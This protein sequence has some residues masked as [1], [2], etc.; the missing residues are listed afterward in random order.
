MGWP[1]FLV[2]WLSWFDFSIGSDCFLFLWWWK[3]FIHHGS[4]KTCVLL[5]HRLQLE[6]I[7]LLHGAG[8]AHFT[9][10]PRLWALSCCKCSFQQL[11]CFATPGHS[12]GSLPPPPPCCP[13]PQWATWWRLNGLMH[14]CWGA[15]PGMSHGLNQCVFLLLFYQ[16]SLAL[17]D[18][19]NLVS[20]Y[21]PFPLSC[22]SCHIDIKICQVKNMWH[23]F[24]LYAF[25]CVVLSSWTA[26]LHYSS[27]VFSC[28]LT[29][30]LTFI[31]IISLIS[32]MQ[33]L[34]SKVLSKL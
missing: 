11:S 3:M 34:P 32:V 13:M 4:R 6:Q 8:G 17:P 24:M 33:T 26:C 28:L 2:C 14:A 10:S 12:A 15:I 20:K 22:I 23:C 18:F 7:L 16:Y 19:S 1:C 5:L 30:V 9:T 27:N 21:S 31:L 29:E 25:N